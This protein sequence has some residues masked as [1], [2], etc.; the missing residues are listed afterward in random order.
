MIRLPVVSF[1]IVLAFAA[2]QKQQ[3]QQAENQDIS[4]EGNLAYGQLPANAEIETLPPDESSE[5][6]S[7]ELQKGDDNPD[8]NDLNA[9][10]N[11]H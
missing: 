5:T 7:G 9:A 2:C 1:L 10:S 4:I 6:S 8:V 11:S 3:S